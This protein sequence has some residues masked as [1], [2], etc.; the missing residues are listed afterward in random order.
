[1]KTAPRTGRFLVGCGRRSALWCA[2]RRPRRSRLRSFADRRARPRS[3]AAPFAR[4]GNP[5]YVRR[6]AG[7]RAK[8]PPRMSADGAWDAAHQ[9]ILEQPLDIVELDLRPHRIGETTAQLL[10]N[11]AGALDVDFARHPYPLIPPIGTPQR[12]T[13]RVKCPVC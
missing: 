9:L 5:E 4:S 8:I 11:A 6:T 12:P 13:Q 3:R 1:M 10:K 7:A 2:R